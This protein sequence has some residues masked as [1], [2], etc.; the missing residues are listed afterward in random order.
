MSDDQSGAP[1]PKLPTQLPPPPSPATP[2]KKRKKTG[3]RAKG[4]PNKIKLKHLQTIVD[5]LKENNFEPVKQILRLLPA[6]TEKEQVDALFKLCEY[7][8]PKRSTVKVDVEH[9]S[10]FE[11]VL[12]NVESGKLMDMARNVTQAI[13]TEP[14]AIDVTEEK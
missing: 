11:Q 14:E 12:V 2:R 1:V 6:L 13:D 5:T 8:Y 4:K 7:V 9:R 3:G 10:K